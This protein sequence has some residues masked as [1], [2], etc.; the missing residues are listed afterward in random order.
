MIKNCNNIKD[1][2]N[3]INWIIIFVYAYPSLTILNTSLINTS[4]L[5]GIAKLNL[6][7]LDALI[8]TC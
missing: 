8:Q 5:V 3:T 2:T 7:W 1:K 4:N 6:I